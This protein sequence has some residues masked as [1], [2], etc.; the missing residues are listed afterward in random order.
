M[1]CLLAL[2]LMAAMPP[3][4]APPAQPLATTASQCRSAA[5]DDKEIVMYQKLD[6]EHSI[7]PPHASRQ[8]KAH[9]WQ[10]KACFLKFASCKV[11]ECDK[12]LERLD[13]DLQKDSLR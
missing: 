4:Q 9:Y 5:H 11:P 13:Q 12:Q 2:A 1:T 10:A 3:Q 8:L 7:I 6:F